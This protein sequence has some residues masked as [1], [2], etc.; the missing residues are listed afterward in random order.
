[1]PYKK[2][3]PISNVFYMNDRLHTQ[4]GTLI[5]TIPKFMVNS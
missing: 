3:Y 2:P 1:M 5:I 4:P